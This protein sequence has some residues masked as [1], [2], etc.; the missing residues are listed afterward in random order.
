MAASSSASAPSHS[1]EAPGYDAGTDSEEEWPDPMK[2]PEAAAGEFIKHLE[3]LYLAS[4]ISARDF[5]ELCFWAEKAG[6]RGPVPQ[7]SFK[8]GSQNTGNYQRHLDL[9]M[10]FTKEM[11]EAYV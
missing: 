3:G 10:G 11:K 2:D 8:P 1:W 7:Y 4:K 9:A 6:V 5:C